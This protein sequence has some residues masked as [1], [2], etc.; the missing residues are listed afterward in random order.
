MAKYGDANVLLGAHSKRVANHVSSSAGARIQA[1]FRFEASLHVGGDFDSLG[2]YDDR[3]FLAGGLTLVHKI[4]DPADVERYFGNQN[5]VRAAG[6]SR[7][8]GNPPRI[9]AHDF[10]D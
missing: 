2:D 10:D 9:P 8:Q 7:L 1:S 3:E 5:D 4:T 6:N